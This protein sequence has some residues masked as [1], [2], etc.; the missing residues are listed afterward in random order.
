MHTSLL[1][2]HTMPLKWHGKRIQVSLSA[3]LQADLD[4]FI[5][6]AEQVLRIRYMECIF[7]DVREMVD[8]I[9]AKKLCRTKEMS[10][11]VTHEV[12]S[13]GVVQIALAG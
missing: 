4:G 9:I 3:W 7:C 6:L 10:S 8:H 11:M 5:Y 12:T 2:E 13:I 1:G